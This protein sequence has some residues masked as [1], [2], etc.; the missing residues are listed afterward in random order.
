MNSWGA[1]RGEV[2]SEFCVAVM[3]C[4]CPAAF[5]SDGGRG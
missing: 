2:L 4:A 1:G 5:V 3:G